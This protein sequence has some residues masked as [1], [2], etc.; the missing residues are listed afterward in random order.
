[1]AKSNLKHSFLK[2]VILQ[3]AFLPVPPQLGGAVEKMWFALGKDFVQKGHEVVHISRTYS[4]MP[5]EEW[6]EGVLHKRVKGYATPSSGLH[7][8]WLDLLYSLRVRS[9]VP[10]DADIVVTNTFWSPLLLPANL[11]QRCIPDVQRVPKGQMRLYGQAARLRANSTPVADAIRQELP[12]ERH[13]QVV[14]IPNPLP[15]QVSLSLSPT[16]KKPVLLYT[17][18]VHPE[19]GLE[20]LIRAFQKLTTDWTLRIVGPSDTSAGGGGPTYLALLQR[21]A[22]TA[23]IEFTG[24]VYDTELLNQMYAEAAIFAYPSI[25][26]KGETFGLAPL[27]AMAWGCVPIVSNLAC[28]HDFIKHESNGL[29]F[30]HRRP[31]ADIL[32]GEAISRLQM[33]T[34][35]RD[36]LA[37]QALAVRQTH[38]TSFIASQFIQEFEE[39]ITEQQY[40]N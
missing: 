17:G 27:E 3:G 36:K 19:K 7:Q 26:E 25:A 33:N 29:V 35:F 4:N 13:Y 37:E 39:I 12:V 10:I 8:K 31:E 16:L 22:G 30:D 23:Q 1:L 34:S 6:I 15:F 14:M 20:M 2:I 21:L 24:P 32:L 40:I 28:F 38:S 11:R 18:R 5:T 9:V